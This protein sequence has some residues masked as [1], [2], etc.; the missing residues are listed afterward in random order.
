MFYGRKEELTR[1][2]RRIKM[3]S[4]SSILVYGKRRIGKTELIKHAINSNNKPNLVLMARKTKASLNLLDFVSDVIKFT[5]DSY[6]NPRNYYEFFSYLFEYGIKHPFVLFIDEFSFLLNDDQ[7]IDSVLQKVIELY[8]DKTKLTL[9]LC[10]SYIDTMRKLIEESNPLYGRFNEIILLKSFDYYESSLFYLNLSNEDKFK[11]YAV[12]GGVAFNLTNLD[13]SIPFEENLINEFIKSDSFFEK[14]AVSTIQNEIVKEENVNA[15]LELIASGVNQFKELN[16]RLGD[17]SKDNLTR[18][19]KK[20]EDLDI[21]SKSYMITDKTNKKPIYFVKDNLLEFYYRYIFK[22]LNVRNSMS[23]EVFFLNFVKEDFFKNYLPKKF[24]QVIKEY[25]IRENG[26]KLPLFT[27]AGRYYFN[28]I[29][30]ENNEQTNFEFDLILKTKKG[31]IPIECKYTKDKINL[32]DIDQEISQLNKIPFLK[33]D[34][35]GFA[36]RSGFDNDVLEKEKDLLLIT[37]DSIYQ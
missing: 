8:K 19:I 28:L 1:I 24:E 30:K 33:I 13:Y 11:Y 10:G 2:N 14:E 36:S 26:K 6:F 37:L 17:P 34:K 5:N 32:K 16:R 15:I 23:K 27:S 4:F 29:N 20:L 25:A 3:D 18:Y 31:I 22:K 21:I 9:I 35:Y 7:E 12:F